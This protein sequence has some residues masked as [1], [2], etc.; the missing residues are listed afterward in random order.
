MIV[1]IARDG[2]DRIKEKAEIAGGKLLRLRRDTDNDGRFDIVFSSSGISETDEACP[3]TDELNRLVFD[4]AI[5][6]IIPWF[7]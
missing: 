5:A 6:C 2:A 7:E 3:P 1:Y 4:H